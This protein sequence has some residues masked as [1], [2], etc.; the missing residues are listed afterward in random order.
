MILRLEGC[1]GTT[2]RARMTLTLGLPEHMFQIA[3]LFMMENSCA[4]LY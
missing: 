3:H 4:N 1:P 2:C